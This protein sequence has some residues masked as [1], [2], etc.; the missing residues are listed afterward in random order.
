MADF[1]GEWL[2]NRH[3][4]TP[5]VVTPAGHYR[6]GR[7]AHAPI[8]VAGG[9]SDDFNNDFQQ[10]K[11]TYFPVK[12]DWL[13]QEIRKEVNGEIGEEFSTRDGTF[14]MRRYK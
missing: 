6:N 3:G 12:G 8:G 9:F 14:N 11:S 13:P 4:A 10:P 2:E 1:V 7:V 5:G